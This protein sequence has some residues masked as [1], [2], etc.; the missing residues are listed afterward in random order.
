V[1][2]SVFILRRNEGNSP[3]R[4]LSAE[5]EGLIQQIL[6]L[7]LEAARLAFLRR[8]EVSLR[9]ATASASAWLR[10]YYN[11]ADPGVRA[12]QAELERLGQLPLAPALPDISRS[13][14]LLRAQ[15][16]PAPR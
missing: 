9:A 3:V 8:D 13:L 4:L 5:Q 7:R 14:T 12:A 2:G 1:M 11:G 15:L 6:Q 16:E 10:D